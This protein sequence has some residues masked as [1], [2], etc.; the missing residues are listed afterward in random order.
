MKSRILFLFFSAV[1]LFT[2]CAIRG[3]KVVRQTGPAII[4]KLDDLWYEDG[5]VH[6]GWVEVMDFLSEEGVIGTIGIVGNSLE[7]EDERYFQWI[8]DRHSEGHEIWHHGFCH[9]REKVGDV[10]VREYRGQDLESQ[11]ISIAKTHQLAKDK[12]GITLRSFGAPY[13][14]T[15]TSTT[16]ALDKIPT[17]KVWMYKET[18]VPT[19]KY[20]LNRIPEVNIEYPVHI[21]DFDQF[22]EG[23]DRYREE[24]ILVIQGH[25]RSWTK[26][27]SRMETFKRIVLFLKEEGVRFVTPYGYYREEVGE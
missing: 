15:D 27:P 16:I 18:Q 25:P 21:P 20:V 13:N 11:C 24:P 9:C 1:L 23:Y 26:D 2:S 4:L 7:T 22:K 8:K 19:D 10:E 17:I 5:L 6:P 12:L 3:K 14:S